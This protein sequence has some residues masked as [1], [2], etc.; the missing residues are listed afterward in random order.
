VKGAEIC[1]KLGKPLH[2]RGFQG[3]AFAEPDHGPARPRPHCGH[4]A[5]GAGMAG[6]Q[7]AA[8]GDN[9]GA[10]VAAS[11]GSARCPRAANSSRMIF[12]VI[13]P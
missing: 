3:F 2:Q 13:L 10:H 7:H 5:F 8:G 6:V 12:L 4:H 9:R 1:V 11:A